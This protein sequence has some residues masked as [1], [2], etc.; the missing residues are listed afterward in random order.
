MD[1]L[2]EY[3]AVGLAVLMSGASMLFNRKKAKLS[4]V[5]ELKA[6]VSLAFDAGKH[7]TTRKGNNVALR[8]AVFH[9]ACVIDVQR[10]GKRDFSDKLLRTAIDAEGH[11]RGLW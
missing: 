2:G 6:V 9:A 8:D 5:E 3:I 1:N 11:K 4:R 7:H 10:D